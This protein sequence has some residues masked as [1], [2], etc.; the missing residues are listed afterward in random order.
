MGLEYASLGAEEALRMEGIAEKFWYAM[1]PS[2][3]AN[4]G[5]AK[6]GCQSQAKGALFRL[7]AAIEVT[8][9]EGS[10]EMCAS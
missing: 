3:T 2:I 4:A 5:R 6:D 7:G 8:G 1:M 10:V 9:P